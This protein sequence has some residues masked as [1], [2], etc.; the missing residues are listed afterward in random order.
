[1]GRSCRGEPCRRRYP[2]TAPITRSRRLAVHACGYRLHMTTPPRSR[3]APIEATADIWWKNAIIYCLDIETFLDVDGDGV[4]DIDGLMTTIDY[5]AGLG[6]TCLWLMPVHPTPNRDDG[7]D[8]TD[9]YDVD[10]RFG[11]LGD[12]VEAIRLAQDRGIRVI[13]DL[14]VNHTS[15]QH[16]WFLDARSSPDAQHRDWYVWTD[17]PSE[18]PFDTIVFPHVEDSAWSWD[19]DAGQHYL[20]RFFHHQP[21]LNIAN[22]EVRDA[23]GEIAGFWL[24]QGIAGFRVDA[25]PYLLETDGLG[26]DLGLDPHHVFRD[27]RR[28]VGRRRGDAALLGEVNLPPHQACE[29]FG[30][31]DELDMAFNFHT[32]QHLWLALA[33][34]DA[35]PLVRS[36]RELPALPADAAWANFVRSHDEVNVGAL[37]DD[38]RAE[39]FAAF[40]PDEDMQ[41][42]GRGLRRRLAPMMGGDL[43]RIRMIY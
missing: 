5:L 8:V 10:P 42:Y 30:D 19:E 9:Y 7:Y 15:N 35:G 37:D 1:M 23:I 2:M 39:V 27:L 24:T 16:P 43:D 29:Y 3:R 26:E 6:I 33:R 28:Q 31:G 17:D 36:L 21:D 40:G 4:G 12:L 38:E 13:L 11:T 14:V 22:P 32:N 41:L 34:E 20:H 25:V 18:T